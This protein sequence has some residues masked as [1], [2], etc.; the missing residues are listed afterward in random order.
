[1]GSVGLVDPVSS[2]GLGLI[3][4]TGLMGPVDPVGSVGSVNL[5]GLT[6]PVDPVVSVGSVNLI[7]FDRLNG[8]STSG[9]Q[10][11]INFIRS[12]DES[13][14]GF[15]GSGNNLRCREDKTLTALIA[16]AKLDSI[17]VFYA[18]HLFCP[19]IAGSAHFV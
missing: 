1:M 5:T 4:L 7:G 9:F 18:R 19:I 2:V 17:S 13:G 16:W 6:E 3:N 10:M 12:S 8:L 11:V 15:F 14:P